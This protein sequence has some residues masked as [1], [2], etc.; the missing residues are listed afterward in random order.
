MKLIL[1]PHCHDV[2]R[3]H[4][5]RRTY[6][7]CRKSW[8]YYKKDGRYAVVN[9][10][11]IPIGLNNYGLEDAIVNRPE[12]SPGIAF[13]AWVFPRKTVRIEV[14]KTRKRKKH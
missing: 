11:A 5:S 13:H 14:R 1:C 4:L 8:G 6:C 7:Q 3:L 9:E 2:R 10:K 12:R